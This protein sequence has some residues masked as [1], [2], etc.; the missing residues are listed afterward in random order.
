MWFRRDLRL[1]DNPAL[2]AAAGQHGLG[3][4]K[5]AVVPLFVI[6][7]ALWRPAGDPRRAHLVASARALSAR[8]G[9]A[10]VAVRQGDPVHEVVL[11][12]RA[13]KATA[14][15]VAADF[16]PYGQRRDDAVEKALAEHGIA[17]VRTGSAYA[18]APGRLHTK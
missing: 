15:H 11:V 4:G 13:V 16:G 1:R 6:D 7:P 17:F 9:D 3:D 10:G 14:V 5:A 2:L 8:L 18:V 12:A